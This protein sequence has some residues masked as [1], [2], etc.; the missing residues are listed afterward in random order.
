MRMTLANQEA[1]FSDVLFYQL[2]MNAFEEVITELKKGEW[3]IDTHTDTY[4]SGSVNAEKDGIL[5]TTIPYEPGWTITVDGTEVEPVKLIDSLIGIELS[6]GE[7]T[8]TMKFRPSY[9][10]ISI[11]LSLIGLS[12]IGIIFILEYKDGAVFKKIL[13]KTK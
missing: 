13:A 3:N 12:L 7:H 11:I 9:L 8:V 2:D 6:A 1:I 10:T 4:L 5:F